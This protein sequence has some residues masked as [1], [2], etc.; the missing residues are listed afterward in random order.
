MSV[1]KTAKSAPYYWFDFQTGGRR[2]HGSTKCTT[3][4]EAKAFEKLE[5]ERAEALIKA[6][7]R[8]AASLAIDDV[9]ARLWTDTAQHDAAPEATSKNLAR[10]VEYFGKATLL[11]DMDHVAAKKMVAWRRGQPS[12]YC[13]DYSRSPRMS[14]HS[15][16]TNR[17]G[18]SCYY[19]NRKNGC[20]SCRTMKLRRS[21][22]RCAV[23]TSRSLISS[24]QAGCGWRS[25]SPCAGPR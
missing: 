19:P 25:V 23:I 13:N 7:K 21:M 2:F 10:L 20:V 8:S 6:T 16:K 9:A 14:A 3:S 1:F 12:R 18:R 22:M 5:R 15:L 4:K 11:T 17:I 24:K